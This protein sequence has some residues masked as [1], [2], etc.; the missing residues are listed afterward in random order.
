VPPSLF[1]SIR[2]R[3]DKALTGISAVEEKLKTVVPALKRL[4]PVLDKNAA[5]LEAVYLTLGEVNALVRDIKDEI[6]AS[7][8]HFAEDAETLDQLIK[9]VTTQREETARLAMI[10]R[11][12]SFFLEDPNTLKD[13]LFGVIK[14][15]PEMKII[16][17]EW[18]N[19]HKVEDS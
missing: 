2:S 5:K 10:T 19:G 6:G 8:G 16:I 11:H 18:M 1:D 13:I 15:R 17:Y 4:Q 14:A 12:V 7:S 9:D 3:T